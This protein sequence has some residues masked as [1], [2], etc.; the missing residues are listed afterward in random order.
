MY[1]ANVIWRQTN[2]W[3]IIIDNEWDARKQVSKTVEWRKM[4]T[5]KASE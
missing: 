1:V 5:Y 3:R 2:I 4:Q